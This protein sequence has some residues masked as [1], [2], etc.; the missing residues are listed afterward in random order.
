MHL[1]GQT[2]HVMVTLDDLT[3]DVERLDA[4][5]IDGTLRQPLGISNLLSLSI[6]HL[7]EVATD[8]LALLLW[9]GNT[10]QVAKELL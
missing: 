3:R 5:R 1:L 10:C 7:H 4:V 6:E 8:N 2:A 9:V